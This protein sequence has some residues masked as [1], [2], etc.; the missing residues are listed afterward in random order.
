MLD[1]DKELEKFKPMLKTSQIEEAIA[2]DTLED[3]ID[4]FKN[5]QQGMAQ[6]KYKIRKEG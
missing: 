2:S 3:I 1:F 5:F 6:D 4:L